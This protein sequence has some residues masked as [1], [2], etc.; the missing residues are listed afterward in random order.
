[1]VYAVVFV[2]CQSLEPNGTRIFRLKEPLY[3]QPNT[4]FI[5]IDAHYLINASLL[6]KI[7]NKRPLQ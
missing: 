6:I 4:V 3:L 2:V 5:P 1:M 7:F